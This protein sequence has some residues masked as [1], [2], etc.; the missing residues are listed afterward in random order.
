MGRDPANERRPLR[1]DV[2]PATRRPWHRGSISRMAACWPSLPTD[3][4]RAAPSARVRRQS[5]SPG[6][7]RQRGLVN[8]SGRAASREL[9]FFVK[10]SGCMLSFECIVGLNEDETLFV[11]V[12]W[13]LRLRPAS[14][15]GDE[16]AATPPTRGEARTAYAYAGDG[17][18]AS[19]CG[20]RR[21]CGRWPVMSPSRGQRERGAVCRV[22]RRSRS[23]SCHAFQ[24][25]CGEL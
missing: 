13:P 20:Q 10:L 7:G 24:R 12:G 15:M 3:D 11:D 6:R 18:A 9:G 8:R 25:H 19:R 14:G 17:P 5:D 21:G 23:R 22:V 1:G 2:R 16:V 4:G